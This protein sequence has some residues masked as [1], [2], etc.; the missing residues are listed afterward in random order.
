[1]SGRSRG[2][3]RGQNRGGSRFVNYVERLV[4]L[5]PLVL[6]DLIKHSKGLV[7]KVC[8]KH[9]KEMAVV[10]VTIELDNSTTV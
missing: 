4:T 3:G 5:S 10:R 7:C 9:S 2:R 1:M 6:R 8:N